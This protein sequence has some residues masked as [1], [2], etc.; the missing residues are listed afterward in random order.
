MKRVLVLVSMSLLTMFSVGCSSDNSVT[1]IVDPP[2]LEKDYEKVIQNDWVFT[3]YQLL[4]ENR[5]VVYETDAKLNDCKNNRWIFKEELN[6]DKVMQK[7]RTDLAYLTNPETKE[8]VEFKKTVPY[9]INKNELTTLL[10]NDGD[11]I[12]VYFFEIREMQKDKMLLIRKDYKLTEE[13]AVKYNY[14]KEAKY[15]Q[16]ELKTTK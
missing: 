14:P 7:T 16:Y 15:L 10:V 2:T 8:C 11:Q 6:D 12:I 3:K 5:K 13:E 9:S 4:D 1:P